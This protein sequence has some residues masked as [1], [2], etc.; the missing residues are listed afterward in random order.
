M[1]R[2]YRNVSCVSGANCGSSG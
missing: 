1:K 2:Y